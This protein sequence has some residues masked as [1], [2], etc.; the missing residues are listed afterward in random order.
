MVLCYCNLS[1]QRESESRNTGLKFKISN[2]LVSL[3]GVWQNID[4]S[5]HCLLPTPWGH[6][7]RGLPHFRWAPRM[8]WWGSA[9]SPGDCVSQPPSGPAG[10][11][12]W[13]SPG[14]G[15]RGSHRAGKWIWVTW[16]G[17]CRVLSSRLNC[18]VGEDSWE[19]PGLQGDP[20]SPS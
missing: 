4:L 15:E 9:H 1:W 14:S 8:T 5:D 17:N 16:G 20:T 10:H 12:L 11:H 7:S 19:S 13:L 2:S 3:S 18:C 6:T